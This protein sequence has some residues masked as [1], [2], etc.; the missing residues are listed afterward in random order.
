MPTALTIGQFLAVG[1]VRDGVI[2]MGS[3]GMAFDAGKHR[4]TFPNDNRRRFVAL[5]T[6]VTKNTY[7]TSTT[8][9]LET[10]LDYVV[11][12]NKALDTGD[13]LFAPDNFNIAIVALD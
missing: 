4:I 13:R 9:V 11:L 5:L 12:A 1:E 3:A 6:D 7:S 10:G 2:L 8:I